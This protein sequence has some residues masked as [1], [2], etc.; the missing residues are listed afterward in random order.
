MLHEKTPDENGW[1]WI[2]DTEGEAYMAYLRAED[3]VPQLV[4][5]IPEQATMEAFYERTPGRFVSSGLG[6]P[7][8]IR[9]QSWIGPL[10]CPFG[11]FAKD[12]AEFSIDMHAKAAHENKSLV[13][14]VAEVRDRH[15]SRLIE[16]GLMT[17]DDAFAAGAKMFNTAGNKTTGD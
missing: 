6:D 8:F 9:P 14:A 7:Q 3:D 17:S 11:D 10:D 16:V 12:I 15:C 13:M 5:A 2:E 1:Y 4:L